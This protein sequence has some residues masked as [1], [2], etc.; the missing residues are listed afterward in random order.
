MNIAPINSLAPSFNGKMIKRG[1]GWTY[2]LNNAYNKYKEL[3]ALSGTCDVVARISSKKVSDPGDYNHFQGQKVYKLK[4]SFLK[5]NS[6]LD[7]IKDFLGLIPRYSLTE[8]Y[9]SEHGLMNRFTQ[10]Y[11]DKLGSKIK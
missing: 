2:S 3:K 5:E 7:K 6:A 10:E 1:F 8:N 4:L 11:V 9:H